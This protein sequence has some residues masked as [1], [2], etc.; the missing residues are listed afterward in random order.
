MLRFLIT[1]AL[2]LATA[3]SDLF[4]SRPEADIPHRS[5]KEFP[6]IIGEWRTVNEQAIDKGSMAVLQVDDY[7]MRNY[8]NGQG[9]VIGLYIGYFKNQKEGKGVHSPRQCLP[10]AGWS[11]L[12]SREYELSVTG[13]GIQGAP[14]NL[15]LM[16]KGT[17][18]QLYLWWYQGRGRIYANEYLNKLYHIW[19]GITMNRTDGALVRVNMAANPDV[20]S[21]LRTEIGF[22]SKFLPLTQQYIPE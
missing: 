3:A 21:T 4:L 13:E 6:K 8:V 1:I 12:E 16:G 2:L 20:E 7:V 9:R 19:D 22:I 11:I 5:L 18:R 17:E 15:Y 14:I 10:G